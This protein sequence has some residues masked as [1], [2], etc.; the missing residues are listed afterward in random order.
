MQ[1]VARETKVLV[2]VQK[3]TSGMSPTTCFRDVQVL[4]YLKL[5]LAVVEFFV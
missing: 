1:E 4:L 5:N 3:E 2:F